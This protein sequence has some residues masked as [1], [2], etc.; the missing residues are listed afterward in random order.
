MGPKPFGISTGLPVGYLQALSPVEPTR[1][2]IIHC[3]TMILDSKTGDAE[4]FKKT[5]AF[6]GNQI[7]GGG[8]KHFIFST[9]IPGEMIHFDEYFSNGLVQPPTR[10]AD[11]PKKKSPLLENPEKVILNWNVY[12][13][14]P[15]WLAKK[16]G[17]NFSLCQ[18]W[19]F[20]KKKS[21]SETKILAV[22][23]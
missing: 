1:L 13:Q 12:F 15:P 19:G 23:P 10:I 5:V 8:F 20:N 11:S 14:S 2:G 18:I 22:S 9:R 7:L 6:S 4:G 3:G 16:C 17:H 21:G